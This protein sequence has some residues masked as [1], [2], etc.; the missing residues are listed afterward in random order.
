M[1]GCGR[2]LDA[3]GPVGTEM[4]CATRTLPAVLQ[5]E[6]CTLILTCTTGTTKASVFPLPVG[7]DTQR[8]LGWYP[9][10]PTRN[11]LSA[12]SKRTGITAAW[13]VTKEEKEQVTYMLG[14]T[15]SPRRS[16]GQRWHLDWIR[17]KII[18]RNLSP[19]M[20]KLTDPV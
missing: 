8:S 12:L 16:P 15:M 18:I 10:L 14:Y 11:P 1:H 2:P 6:M 3:A 5:L 9:P 13:T 19:R 17:P 7:A 20:Q 4:I